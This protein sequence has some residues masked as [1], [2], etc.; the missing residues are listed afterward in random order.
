M[1]VF[2]PLFSCSD[3]TDTMASDINELKK[4]KLKELIDTV[5][6]R[7]EFLPDSELTDEDI[8]EIISINKI[9]T[10]RDVHWEWN[11]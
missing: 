8:Q 4:Q 1:G 10:G 6:V 9:A 11:E 5:G 2:L 7:L 3:E